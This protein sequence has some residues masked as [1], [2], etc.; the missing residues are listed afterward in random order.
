MHNY[1]HFHAQTESVAGPE[2]K[3][4]TVGFQT[5][6]LKKRCAQGFLVFDTK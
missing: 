2:Q 3:K 1:K 6:Q 5:A 4:K